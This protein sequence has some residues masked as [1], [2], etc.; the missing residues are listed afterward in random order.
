MR[1][2]MMIR[3][4]LQ[5]VP[6]PVTVAVETLTVPVVYFAYTARMPRIVWLVAVGYVM[7]MNPFQVKI[8]SSRL[9]SNRLMRRVAAA[10]ALSARK[11]QSRL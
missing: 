9:N 2:P 1:D 7:V 3:S 10:V 8:E 6:L 4:A 11:T 5:V